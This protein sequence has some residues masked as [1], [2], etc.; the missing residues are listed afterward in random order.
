MR[1]NQQELFGGK[2]AR[3]MISVLFAARN[4]I[5]KTIPGLDVWDEDRDAL[6][7][8][9]G[10]PGIFHPPCRL[11]S[12]IAY[13][14]KSAPQEEKQLGYWSVDAVRKNGGVLEQPANSSLWRE[15]E[16]AMPG[17]SDGDGFSISVPQFWFGHKARKNTW[18]YICGMRLKDLP[19]IP[20]KL[21]EAT[22]T[23]GGGLS[24]S[25]KRNVVYKPS[26]WSTERSA[27]PVAFAHW[28]VES[29]ERAQK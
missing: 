25:R 1:A 26:L 21:G 4:S 8:P 14:A 17:S 28:L 10:N 18:L 20:F 3:E 9:G 24:E 23:V 5:Y 13:L 29:A 11:F 12:Q 6:K 16:I 22:H 15:C 27:T 19:S 7:W 2:N